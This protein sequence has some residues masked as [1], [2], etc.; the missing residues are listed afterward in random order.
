MLDLSVVTR[1]LKE[2]PVR[3]VRFLMIVGLCAPLAL[4]PLAA[5]TP[6]RIGQSVTG[7]LTIADQAFN[8]GS[9][10]KMYAFV[11]NKGDT[12]AVDLISDDFD[13][14]IVVAD[15][16][17]NRLASNDDSGE[18]CNARLTYVLPQAANYRVYA[19][20][21]AAA[22]LGAY[23]LA[24]A[25]G[26]AAAATDTV[27]RGF[28]RVAGLIQMGQTVTGNL[29]ANDPEFPGDST[30]F[31]RWIL[32]VTPNQ[33]F[34]VDLES[35]EFDAYII[36]THG[37]GDKVVENDDGGGGCNARLVYTSP[38]DHPLRV[39]VNT[40]SRPPR[41][42][43]HFT[44]KVTD[45]ESPTEAKGNC[46]F[47][48]PSTPSPAAAAPAPAPSASH[49]ITAGQTQ[50]GSLSRNDVLLTSDSSYAQAWTIQGRAGQ[51]VT[52]DLESDEFDAYLFLRGPGISGGRDFQDDDSGGNCNARLT[53]IF[54]QTGE[55][56]V[57]VNTAGKYATGAFTLSIT[58][59]SKPKSVARC[60]RSQ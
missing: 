60:S 3:F 26:K 20:S 30:Y 5:Q 4:P 23:R 11:G 57:V 19:N 43:G 27:C 39:V 40:A 1:R 9:R 47:S 42:T 14:N 36:L 49:S 22:E 7:R 44:L 6:I 18:N 13:A 38:D 50:Q 54:P 25:R 51:T 46:R 35:S 59:G 55:Y 41:Q 28:G 10:Y 56:E 45:G 12:V 53:A 8:D 32:P 29:T 24:M 48:R 16:S 17:G 33:A 15:A 21:S 34:T 31:Q 37:R 58:T 2:P 52:I